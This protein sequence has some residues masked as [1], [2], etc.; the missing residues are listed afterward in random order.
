M[1]KVSQA[2]Q[3]LIFKGYILYVIKKF[4]KYYN[5]NNNN[6]NNNKILLILYLFYLTYILQPF[7]INIFKTFY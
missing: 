1:Q 3:L 4:E 2:Y 7:N 6:N 5:N